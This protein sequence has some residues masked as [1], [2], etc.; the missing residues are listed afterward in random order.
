MYSISIQSVYKLYN[1]NNVYKVKISNTISYMGDK[2]L[3]V[4]IVVRINAKERQ[5]LEK[6]AEAQARSL[7]NYIKWL[8]MTHP[9]RQRSKK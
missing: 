7:S 3:E 2:P 1:V 4:S 8:L 9:D 5:A 6:E